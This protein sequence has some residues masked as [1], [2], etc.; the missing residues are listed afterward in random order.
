[1]LRT[2]RQSILTGNHATTTTTTIDLLLKLK[3]CEFAHDFSTIMSNTTRQWLMENVTFI[4][5]RV[6]SMGIRSFFIL[7]FIQEIVKF[8]D[9]WEKKHQLQDII[10]CVQSKK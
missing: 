10:S 7:Y 8:C 1:M 2:E 6:R 9:Q 3:L 4:K 5:P